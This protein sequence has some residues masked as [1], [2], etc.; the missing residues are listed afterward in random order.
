MLKKILKRA[1]GAALALC[2]TMT[3][4]TSAAA[5]PI[6]EGT[7]DFYSIS[8]RAAENNLALQKAATASDVEANT[9]FTADLAVDGSTDTRW[10][11]NADYAIMKAPKWLRIDFGERVTFDNV[12]IQWEQ[13]NIYSYQI[14]VSDNGN[15]WSTVYERNSAPT[16]K[17]E[18]VYLSFFVVGAEFLSYTVLHYEK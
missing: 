14:Q 13:Q 18:S 6:Y 5:Q 4:V 11:S 7:S 10:A 3:M 12:E 15:Q 17:N 16:T 8:A 9:S 2:M 1:V